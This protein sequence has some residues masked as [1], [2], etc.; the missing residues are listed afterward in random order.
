MGHL[1]AIEYT[2]FG[3]TLTKTF[4]TEFVKLKCKRYDTKRE[5]RRV[6]IEI[7]ENAKA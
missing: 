1:T 6:N 3:V 7:L 2:A 4:I 5:S